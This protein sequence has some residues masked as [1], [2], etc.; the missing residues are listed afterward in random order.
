MN[1]TRK[2][3]PLACDFC[4]HRKRRC[5]GRSPCATCKDSQ[6]PCIYKELPTGRTGSPPSSYGAAIVERLS[7]IEALLGKQG[8]RLSEVLPQDNASTKDSSLLSRTC[9]WAHRVSPASWLEENH[10]RLETQFLVPSGHSATLCWLLSLQPIQT[11]LGDLPRS[12]FYGL[13]EKIA[14]PLP[15]NIFQPLPGDWSPLKADRLQ[16]LA[17]AYFKNTSSHF[18]L[19]TRQ[20]YEKLQERL[21]KHGP[22]QDLETAICFS[23]CSLGCVASQSENSTDPQDDLG[24]KYFAVSLRIIMA[25][26]IMNFTPSLPLCQALVLAALYF[27][28]LG[29][30]LHAWKMI[31]YAGQQFVQMINLGVDSGDIDCIDEN[32][33]RVFWYCFIKECDGAA[34]FNVERNGIEPLGDKMR[35]P[36]STDISEAEDLIYLAAEMTIRRL[37]NRIIGSLYSPDNVNTGLLTGSFSAPGCKN[38]KQLLALTSEL[39]RQLEQYYTTIPINPSLA[40]D[41]TSNDKRRILKLRSLYA[42]HLI[43]RPFVLCVALQPG[44]QR[45]ESPPSDNQASPSRSPTPK[46]PQSSPFPMARIILEKCYACIQSCEAFI[47]NVPDLLVKRTPYLWTVSQSCLASFIVLFLASR[48]PHLRHMTPDLDMLAGAFGP[49]LQLWATPGSSFEALLNMVKSLLSSRHV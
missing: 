32:H 27:D 37:T 43:Y 49:K 9:P 1:Y 30:P 12:Y 34:E 28:C 18:P 39:N 2:R 16:E 10:A 24:L 5:D 11:I 40:V 33:I 31:H 22:Q 29:R 38:L 20:H 8:Q 15:L 42:R 19:L 47:L 21:L 26:L 36:Q 17:D 48:S 46:S 25:K 44:Q 3:L 41:P 45:E 13:E 14:L 23:V 35:L 6:A 7:Q 4:R